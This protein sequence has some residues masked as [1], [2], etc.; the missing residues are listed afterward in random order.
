MQ[1]KTF[2]EIHIGFLRVYELDLGRRDGALR[3]H[4]VRNLISEQKE[5]QEAH[6]ALSRK[7]IR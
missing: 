2:Q 5:K 3:L 4:N 1:D 7:G 6:Q